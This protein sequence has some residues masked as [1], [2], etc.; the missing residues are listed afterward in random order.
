MQRHLKGIFKDL[1]DQLYEGVYLVE[2]SRRIVYWNQGAESITGFS[3][4]HTLGHRCSDNLLTHMDKAGTNLCLGHCPVVG[5]L[6]DGQPREVEAFLHHRDGHRV[7]VAIRVMP[8]TDPKG[9]IIGAIEIF[10]D[11]SPK[12]VLQQRLTELEEHALL[13]PLTQVANRR[14]LEIQL[15]ARLH[16]L[17]RYGWPTGI[18][19]LDI[20]HFKRINDT[21][22]HVVG[23][24][25]LKTVASNLV[26]NARP[27]DFVGRWGG[28][29]F[30][31]LARNVDAVDLTA[32]AERFRL[33]VASSYLIEEDEII[34]VTISLGATLLQA[35]DTPESALHR[36]DSLMYASK[37]AGRNRL[38]TD[39]PPPEALAS[40]PLPGS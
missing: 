2:P 8:A 29:E 35:A 22:G 9:K 40:S 25:V 31:C 1:V 20:D 34:R 36:A 16:E 18:I 27:F 15:D 7:P 39:S 3:A 32:L 24:K 28:E 5:T 30:V 21:Y 23:D 13:D 33:L 26:T 6:T 17:Q 10:R 19:F 14:A 4:A 37:T 38:T 12:I 11:L